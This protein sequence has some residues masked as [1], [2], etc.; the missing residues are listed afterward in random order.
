MRFGVFND[1]HLHKFRQ[2]CGE[3][4]RRRLVSGLHVL[5]VILRTF[6]KERCDGIIFLGD[7]FHQR[8]AVDVDTL[9]STM[10]VFE[11]Y[12]KRLPS[13]RLAIAGNHDLYRLS[14]GPESISFLRNYGW[15]V[16]S[17]PCTI[18]VSNVVDFVCIRGLSNLTDADVLSVIHPQHSKSSRVLLA[19][20]HVL[21]AKM[22]GSG[23]RTNKGLSLGMCRKTFALSLF[24]DIHL[25]QKLQGNVHILGSPMQ[26]N[27]GDSGRSG[28]SIIDTDD[29]SRLRRISL[30]GKSPRFITVASLSDVKKDGNY[31]RVI[32]PADD[33]TEV[34][35]EDDYV[36]VVRGFRPSIDGGTILHSLSKGR[37]WILRKYVRSLVDDRDDRKR[38]VE[39]GLSLVDGV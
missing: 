30:D 12:G 2:F 19:H 23:S 3:D 37:K 28:I 34:V 39:V 38:L 4:G 29:L 15:D 13:F 26:H 21:R 36:Q 18:V 17:G 10:A 14:G 27:F 22:S 25:H 6:I 31:Y 7:L 35:G 8:G 5:T 11:K 1:L 9:N 16:V 33:K 24:G 20:A 32:L